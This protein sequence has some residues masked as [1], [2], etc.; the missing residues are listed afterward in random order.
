[1]TPSQRTGGIL[2]APAATYM[3]LFFVVPAIL[4]FSYSFWISSGFRIVPDFVLTNYISAIRSPLFLRVTYNAIVIGLVTASVTLC[5]SIPVGYYLTYVARSKIIFYLI[6]V[7]WF[8]SY[9][10][11]IYA[12]RTLLGTN[13]LLN[14]VLLQLGIVDT[15]VQAFL[16]SPFA[17]AITL[18][19]IYLPF[20]ILM[21]V[22]A[23]SEIKAEL[24]EASRDLGTSALGAFFRVVAPNAAQGL[25]GAFMLTF[26]LVAGDYVTPQM[27]GGSSGQ[28]TGLLI[29]DQFRKTG[30]WPLGAAQAFLMFL[31][32]LVIYALVLALGR[33]TGL[34]PARRKTKPAREVA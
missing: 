11:R 2:A 5:L 22:S 31:V 21:V 28:T 16:F 1:M 13:G 26:I 33:L 15:P 12:W 25:I 10:V 23:M 4:L 29:A 34:I 19:H 24:I 18:T 9:L 8:S 32:S 6:L 17:V 14:A 27:V 3:L 20:A 30:N 7:T